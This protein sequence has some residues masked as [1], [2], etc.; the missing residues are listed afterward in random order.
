MTVLLVIVTNEISHLSGR[1][2]VM[3]FV[4]REGVFRYVA[5]PNLFISA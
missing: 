1:A 4:D 5:Y 3:M 2:L